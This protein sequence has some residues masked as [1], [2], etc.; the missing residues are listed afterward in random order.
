MR[1]A[2]G[3]PRRG[4]TRPHFDCISFY[5]NS[6]QKSSNPAFR[7]GDEMGRVSR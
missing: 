7:A 4:D 2:K 1:P 3:A 6:F 5:R